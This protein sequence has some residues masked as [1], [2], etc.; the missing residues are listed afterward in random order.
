MCSKTAHI[1]HGVI[2]KMCEIGFRERDFTAENE[3]FSNMKR[4]DVADLKTKM[5]DI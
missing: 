2:L 3:Q 5:R 4:E 1:V